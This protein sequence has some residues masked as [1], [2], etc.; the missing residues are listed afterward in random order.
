MSKYL[1]LLAHPSELRAV[2]QWSVW[3]DPVYPREPE[4]ESENLKRCYELL[5]YTSRSFSA[6]IQE[7]SPE[8]R[9][10]IAIFYLILRGLD[11]IED[12]MTIPNPTKL[13]ILR[14]F[15][16]VIDTPGWTYNDSKEKDAVV[17]REFDK[18]IIEY[19]NLKDKYKVVIKDITKEM[20]HGMASYC[21]NE[22]FNKKG[23]DTVKDYD[24]YCHYVA[25][26]IGDGLTRL[27]V[28]AGVANPKL[29]DNPQLYESM[30]LL[31]Q[32]TN[33]IRDYHEDL[34]DNRRFWPKEIWQ[35]YAKSLD[36]FAKPENEAAGLD[37]LSEMV[38]NAIE[39][40]PDCLFYL[41]GI[42]EQSMFNF[43]T[44][45]QVM[46]I[47]TLELVYRNP[48]VLT[49]HVKIR[50]GLACKL[51]LEAVNV[52][53]TYDTF[54]EYCHKIQARNTPRDPMYVRISVACAKVDQFIETVFPTKFVPQ[55]AANNAFLV[56]GLSFAVVGILIVY[57]IFLLD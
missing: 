45:P 29:L 24:L 34:M 54:Q 25:G 33:I 7:L 8:L 13:P 46:A 30:G 35:K 42:K 22:D 4:K 52:R 18:V 2:I 44:I 16:E 40:V 23:V 5:N 12:D 11:T 10:V 49:G 57:T 19:Q 31:L 28:E 26:I 9:V 17:L 53:T 32:K 21:E 41:A 55:T 47:A 38:A 48:K 3:H 14:S 37:C 20:G 50:K 43:C 36:D 39:H 27:G 56:F 6:V 15:H 51:M 1:Q